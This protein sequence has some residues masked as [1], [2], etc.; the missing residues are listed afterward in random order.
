MHANCLN[1][2][3]L[4][5]PNLYQPQPDPAL[6][7]ILQHS[8]AMGSAQKDASSLDALAQEIEEIDQ[9]KGLIA[10]HQPEDSLPA[11]DAAAYHG[12]AGAF[13][14]AV[15]PYSEAHPVGILLHVLIPSG[16]LI[17]AGPHALVERTPHPARLNALLVGPTA[18]GRKGMAWS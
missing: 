18:G 9:G 10:P 1:E 2:R 16:C 8:S 15:E 5:Q 14:Q 6:A 3:T 4:M 11:L 17:G 13:T 12:L 7:K